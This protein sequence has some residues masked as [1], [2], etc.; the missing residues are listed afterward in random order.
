MQINVGS[1]V[2]Q[3]GCAY[4]ERFVGFWLAFAIPTIALLVCPVVLFIGRNRYVKRPPEGSVLP[5]A[6]R[7]WRC[8][9][10]PHWTWNPKKLISNTLNNPQFW[11]RAVPSNASE[12]QRQKWKMTWSDSWVPE[13]RRGVIACKIC[14]WAPES[15]LTPQTLPFRSTSSSVLA[16]A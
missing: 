8:A 14:A 1:L 11:D 13:L 10:Q 2:G 5:S 7:A 16:P 9:M 4:A 12:E 3:I 15:E 6:F